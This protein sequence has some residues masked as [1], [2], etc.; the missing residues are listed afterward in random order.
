MFLFRK[1]LFFCIGIIIL[2]HVF[3][4]YILIL[5][6]LIFIIILINLVFI[7]TLI[8]YIIT[9]VKIIIAFMIIFNYNLLL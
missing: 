3:I 1:L 9:I 4:V 6:N 7:I 5:V 8:N 2:V